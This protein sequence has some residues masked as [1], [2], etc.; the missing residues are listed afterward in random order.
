MAKVSRSA[1]A[2]GNVQ[3]N[4]TRAMV[5]SASAELAGEAS[6]RLVG[7]VR[8]AHLGKHSQSADSPH[9]QI[10]TQRKDDG[11]GLHPAAGYS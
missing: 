6:S 2:P 4:W 7:S 11:G 10:A 9:I 8:M 5:P 3:V 1:T